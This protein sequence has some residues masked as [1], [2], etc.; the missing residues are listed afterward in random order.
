MDK[1][2][3]FYIKG[4]GIDTEDEKNPNY[5]AVKAFYAK[6]NGNMKGYEEYQMKLMESVNTERKAR[7]LSERIKQPQQAKSFTLNAIDGREF[8]LSSLRGKVVVINFWGVWCSW[9]VKEMPEFQKLADKYAKDSE[10]VILTINNDGD[11]SMVQQ[12]MRQNK[13]NFP[14]L[15]ENGYN[16]RAGIRNYPTTWFIDKQG[17]LTYIK[18]TYTKELIEEFSLRIEDLKAEK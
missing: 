6:K 14:V 2:E 16:D 17:R 4:L 11:S 5:A 18:R 15:M 1:A 8:S 7:V 12:F 13:Y 9:C 3:E 10:V